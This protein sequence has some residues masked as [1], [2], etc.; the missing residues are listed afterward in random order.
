MSHKLHQIKIAGL[1]VV[2]SPGDPD[3]KT[4]LL[5][6]GFG[7]NAHDLAP[8]SGVMPKARWLFP[9]AP[10]E[11]PI[12]PGYTGRAWFPLDIDAMQ[13]SVQNGEIDKITEVFP[14]DITEAKNLG[15][16]LIEELNIPHANLFIGGFSQG[17]V[18]A[19]EIAFHLKEKPGGLVILSGT[20][21][22]EKEW[23]KKA[24]QCADM[25]FF[26][27]HG[28]TD[29]LLPMG[30]AKRLAELLKSAGLRGELFPFHGGHEIP[31]SAMFALNNFLTHLTQKRSE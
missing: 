24:P 28:D 5:F 29:P 16:R 4:I 10:H 18:L 3:E 23:Q 7:A 30:R 6:H 1:D 8:L 2:E 15:L 25:P 27:S 31:Q 22:N 19:T 13:Q 21:V 17:A 9:E 26:Q 20:L 12:A 14:I 11:V